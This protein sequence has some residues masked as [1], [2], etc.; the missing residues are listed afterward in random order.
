MKRSTLA[1][2]VI[3]LAA[4]L[5]LVSSLHATNYKLIVISGQSNS[6]NWSYWGEGPF[7]E[8]VKEWIND[9]AC[10]ALILT[11]NGDANAA[12]ESLITMYNE[13]LLTTGNSQGYAQVVA[14]FADQY[15][16]A[17]DPSA[18]I[19][20]VQKSVGATSL[21]YWVGG[22]RNGNN[23]FATGTPPWSLFYAAE[24]PGY[25][26]LFSRIRR[27]KSLLDGSPVEGAGF[28]WY[29]G[30]GN[31]G[32]TSGFYIRNIL[33]LLN[34]AKMV[35]DPIQPNWGDD[36]NV[37]FTNG[38]RQELDNPNMP[39]IVTRISSDFIGW[40]SNF[41][42]PNWEPG[43][44][45]TRADQVNA[46]RELSPSAFINVDDRPV[47]DGYHYLGT[48][49]AIISGRFAEAWKQ[50]TDSPVIRPERTVFTGSGQEVTITAPPGG[51][52]VYYTLDG[53]TP[54]AGSTAYSAPF[55]LNHSATVKAVAYRGGVSVGPVVEKRFTKLAALPAQTPAET[56]PGVRVRAYLPENAAIFPGFETAVAPFNP[57]AITQSRISRGLLANYGWN[58]LH[59]TAY[60]N[61]PQ[62]DV[63]EFQVTS[64]EWRAPDPSYRILI[65]DTPVDRYVA[66]KA[67]LHAFR[68][69]KRPPNGV[70]VLQIKGGPYTDFTL[71][72]PEIYS[73]ETSGGG[74][75][76][77]FEVSRLAVN[78][79][80]AAGSI[81]SV[82]VTSDVTSW[83]AASDQGWLTVSPGA[84]AF[85]EK[86]VLTAEANATVSPRTATITL[87]GAG[88]TTRT[89]TVTQAASDAAP[90]E[91]VIGSP[92]Q[93]AT[94]TIAITSAGPWSL[95]NES[96]AWFD[97]IPSSGTGNA[98][99][100]I[101]AQR[102]ELT[103]ERVG[104]VQVDT[105][106]PTAQRVRVRQGGDPAFLSLGA[107]TI[108][109]ADAANANPV[110]L[111]SVLVRSNI[112]WT[113]STST[114]WLNVNAAAQQSLNGS[115]NGRIWLLANQANP[116][117]QPREGTVTLSAAGL[118][119]QNITII[120]PGTAPFLAANPPAVM[121]N[122]GD[123]ATF[124]IASNQESWDGVSDQ[125][126]LTVSK[127]H[128][129]KL[130]ILK[131]T[132]N[133]TGVKRTANVTITSGTATPIVVPVTQNA[134]GKFLAFDPG[135]GTLG[136]GANQSATVLIDA[137]EDW[138]VTSVSAP[139]LD[140]SAGLP[141]N[142]AMTGPLLREHTP[143]LAPATERR[144]RRLLL[145]AASANDTGAGRQAEV[146]LT[147]SSGETINAAVTQSSNV[148]SLDTSSLPNGTVNAA[149]S[150]SLQRSGGKS[151]F[152]WTVTGGSLPAGLT[153]STGG[154]I[155]GTPTT[156]GTSNFTVKDSPVNGT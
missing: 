89:F 146:V 137:D 26:S 88:A 74:N 63:Y 145:S 40:G 122:R 143:G 49:L 75:P 149:Y 10:D 134:V 21:D 96:G 101:R 71:L 83:T 25:T 104:W 141:V 121:L 103:T 95:A 76:V 34:G 59:C 136:A 3:A 33:D 85:H 140:A 128:T 81:E 23:P 47:S 55:T 42:P 14:Y 65:N 114:P 57:S 46:T 135:P 112:N 102:N 13:Q 154:V 144:M 82:F 4:S 80:A 17:I 148:L 7:P 15:W 38:I 18:K 84:G 19:V 48:D 123:A 156:Q 36:P 111:D 130:F 117:A 139:W 91:A 22:G 70:L 115:S 97:C 132:P 86:L 138:T 11:D 66:L 61:I 2:Q 62:D 87:S 107:T 124:H 142:N 53:S 16:K 94:T 9:P 105:G 58:V 41:G 50:L 129:P 93:G 69:D 79:P 119:S 30:E 35:H 153:L 43:R 60:I 52:T 78:L 39:L 32:D 44:Q 108:T 24:G 98:T 109:L 150:Q 31:A 116:D 125:S 67:G 99:V 56:A 113:A 6:G 64:G 147:S 27:A 73:H 110:N 54:T 131:A 68:F 126:W 151:P 118:P 12:D 72:A 152:T 127:A 77:S 1:S 106:G 29:Q 20:V 8:G 100:T 37:D 5:L 92:A 51:A 120:Q 28:F 45:V 155:S 133:T 90:L